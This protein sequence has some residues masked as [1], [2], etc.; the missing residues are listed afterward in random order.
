MYN[1]KKLSVVPVI[2]SVDVPTVKTITNAM[3]TKSSRPI[4]VIIILFLLVPKIF[5]ILMDIIQKTKTLSTKS[6]FFQFY[7]CL[8]SKKMLIKIT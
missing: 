7:I 3:A 8:Y 4:A 6:F 5:S 2:C 1:K